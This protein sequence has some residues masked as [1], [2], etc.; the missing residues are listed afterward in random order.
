VA[1]LP[2]VEPVE[3]FLSYSHKDEAL[4][5]E[6]LNH[7]AVLKRQHVISTWHDREIGAGREWANEIDE[8]LD[9][10]DIILLLISS[11]FLASDYC[12]DIELKRA[13]ERHD[14][15]EARVIPV[16]LRRVDWTGELFDRLQALPKDAKP[17]TEWPNRDQ[18]LADVARGIRAAVEE[19]LVERLETLFGKFCKAEALRNWPNAISLG[20]RILKSVPGRQE[21]RSRTAAAYVNRWLSRFDESSLDTCGHAEIRTKRREQE[22]EIIDRIAHD[23]DRAMALDPDN[24]EFHYLRFSLRLVVRQH[25][26]GIQRSEKGRLEKAAFAD[27]E[28]AIELRPSTAKYY[29]ARGRMKNNIDDEEGAESDFRRARELGYR[30]RLTLY[31][32]SEGRKSISVRNI[33]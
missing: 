29:A 11:D 2:P 30:F 25:Q 33:E 17:V 10:A 4:R 21:I 20:E 1:S 6:L 16:I 9:S 14:A 8:H 22:S 15:G 13:M 32:R 5:D 26:S 28:R 24:A 12:H 27:L 23:L 18:A 7:L 31:L 3:L 19:L